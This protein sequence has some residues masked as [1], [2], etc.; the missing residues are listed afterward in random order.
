MNNTAVDPIEECAML[1]VKVQ[2]LD[3]TEC[4]RKYSGSNLVF[5]TD[6]I[7]KSNKEKGNL[8]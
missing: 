6:K 8:S 1:K 2:R 5:T 4:M 7:Q 3:F